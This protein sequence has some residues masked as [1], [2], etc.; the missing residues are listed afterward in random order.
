[1]L[2]YNE[3]I[4]DIIG[5]AR[6]HQVL[7]LIVSTIDALAVGKDKLNFLFELMS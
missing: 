5:L 2:M 7:L 6:L 3:H 1:M 4:R